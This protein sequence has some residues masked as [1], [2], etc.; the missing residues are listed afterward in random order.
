[1]RSVVCW[2]GGGKGIGNRKKSLPEIQIATS[3]AGAPAHKYRDATKCQ[4][5]LTTTV[6][7][8]ARITMYVS[9]DIL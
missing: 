5:V 4:A 1:M 9:E 6:I 7:R 2:K 8:M 3:S